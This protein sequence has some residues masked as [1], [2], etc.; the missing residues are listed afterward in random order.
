MSEPDRKQ[1]PSIAP[2]VQPAAPTAPPADVMDDEEKVVA[3][4]QDANMPALLTRDVPGG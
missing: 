2:T 4:Q 1:L 3:G